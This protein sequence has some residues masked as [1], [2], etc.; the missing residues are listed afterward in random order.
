[1]QG[2]V[3]LANGEIVENAKPSGM[4]LKKYFDNYQ[5]YTAGLCIY[6]EYLGFVVL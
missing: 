4:T 5:T 3:H 2:Q 1:M 6:V